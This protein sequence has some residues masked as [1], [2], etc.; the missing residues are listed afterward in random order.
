MHWFYQ[1]TNP[2]LYTT[3][4]TVSL[5]SHNFNAN[6]PSLFRRGNGLA[7]SPPHQPASQSL[8]A[9]QAISEFE[10]RCGQ[11]TQLDKPFHAYGSPDKLFRVVGKPISD[12]I[13]N[14][15]AAIFSIL[16][17]HVRVL[18]RLLSRYFIGPSIQ[19]FSAHKII[20]SENRKRYES[21]VYDDH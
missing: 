16:L 10:N 13:T 17:W 6:Y 19:P 14:Y 2:N 20:A 9:R 12:P 3:T 11:W 21:H 8:I 4:M 1:K 5:T 18:Y 15:T 7:E